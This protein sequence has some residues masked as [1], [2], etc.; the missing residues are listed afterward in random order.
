MRILFAGSPDF[1]VPALVA[2][3]K[4]FPVAAVLTN[5]DKPVGRGKQPVPTAVKREALASPS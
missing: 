3:R 4:A 1:A 2:V 5:P